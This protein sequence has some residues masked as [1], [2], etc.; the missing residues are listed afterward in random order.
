[1]RPSHGKP[2]L[3]NSTP[4]E[5][6]AATEEATPGV[7]VI[8]AVFAGGGGATI[9]P[10]AIAGVETT[11]GADTPKGTGGTPKAAEASSTTG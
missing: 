4:A 5:E 9:T 3:S 6:T 10:A 11:K 1:M 8:G 2:C 7:V